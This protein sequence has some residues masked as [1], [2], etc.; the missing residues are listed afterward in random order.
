MQGK[1]VEDWLDQFLPPWIITR[2]NI[3][4][5]YPGDRIFVLGFL[6]AFVV[7]QGF[8]CVRVAS[9]FSQPS[10]IALL[11][12]PTS[13]TSKEPYPNDDLTGHSFVENFLTNDGE[14]YSAVE[15]SSDVFFF[16]ESFRIGFH[17]PSFLNS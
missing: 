17:A 13:L 14:N 15:N 3:S 4:F 12:Q 16:G 5:R 7:R 8:A 9:S 1:T 10:L 6:E 11:F 2:R